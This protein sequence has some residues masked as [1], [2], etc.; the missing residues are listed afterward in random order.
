MLSTQETALTHTSPDLQTW[1]AATLQAGES[2]PRFADE[3]QV[4]NFLSGRK[5]KTDFSD[6]CHIHKPTDACRGDD[7]NQSAAE[8]EALSFQPR[9]LALESFSWSDLD[10][11]G[12][13]E[14]NTPKSQFSVKCSSY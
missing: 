8:D 2:Y 5:N 7:K 10:I 11:F 4:Q 9:Q 6:G 13:I 3:R 14:T 12:E 1:N